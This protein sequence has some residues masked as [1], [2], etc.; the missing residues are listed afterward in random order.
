MAGPNLQ[1]YSVDYWLKRRRARYQANVS[2]ISIYELFIGD[3]NGTGADRACEN[4][5][6][7]Q[8]LT[9]H[10]ELKNVF[11]LGPP[12]NTTLSLLLQHLR[13]SEAPRLTDL[14]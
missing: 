10:V 14:A 7:F 5:R 8:R 1:Y 3:W 11:K 6:S 12:L 4:A 2:C 13:R 9:I